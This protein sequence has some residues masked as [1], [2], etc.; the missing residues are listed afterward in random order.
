MTLLEAAAALRRR[1]ISSAELTATAL[2]PTSRIHRG[3]GASTQ[4]TR[5]KEQAGITDQPLREIVRRYGLECLLREEF[6]TRYF[7]P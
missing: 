4:S 1:E 5:A 2:Q 6:L 3:E 7:T